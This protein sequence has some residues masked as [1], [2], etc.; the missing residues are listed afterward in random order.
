MRSHC[1]SAG[2]I[3]V[4]AIVTACP[5]LSAAG[6][7]EP[8]LFDT[9][10]QSWQPLT[11][12]AM[13]VQGRWTEIASGDT[14]HAFEGDAVISDDDVALV[15]R[16]GGPGAEVY[17]RSTRGWQ[18]CAALLP[19]G[20]A[21][22]RTLGSLKIAAN[23]GGRIDLDA[24]YKSKEDSTV[25]VR[26]GLAQGRF[27]VR[28]LDGARGVR[29][30]APCHY[31]VLPDPD[32][33]AVL[34]GA[35]AMTEGQTAMAGSGFL[36]HMLA[37][38]SVIVM[39]ESD[40]D[41]DIQLNV[42]GSGT[43]KLIESSDI[44]FGKSRRVQVRVLGQRSLWR[45]DE[46]AGE[47]D[48]PPQAKMTWRWPSPAPWSES[49]A[50]P[51]QRGEMA[52]FEAGSAK[53]KRGPAAPFM[54]L[55]DAG[56]ASDSPLT[57]G[58]LARSR[59][60]TQVPEEHLAH[61]FEGDVVFMN[62]KLAAVLRRNGTG[63]E[64]YSRGPG[65][66]RL[67]ATLTP[68]GRG[69]ASRLRSVGVVKNASDG[70][71]VDALFDAS[72]GH[73]LGLRYEL[74]MGQ[75]FVKVEPLE[76]T[77]GLQL[78]APCRFG[79]LPDFFADDMVIDA[80]DIPVDRAELPSE[81]FLMHLIG[82]GEAAIMAVWENSD[83][84][85]RVEFEGDGMRREMVSSEVAFGREGAVWV[86]ILS[87]P[88]IWH[89]RDI[90]PQDK[91]REIPLEWQWPFPG[92]WRVTWRRSDGL[93]D[94]W[95]MLTE[96]Y[97]GSFK[98][99]GLFE[100]TEDAWTARDWWGGGHPRT[101]I[102]SGLGRFHY[103]C[104]V[105]RY[106]RGYLEP[107]KKKLEFKG[108]AIVYPLNR[109]SSTP[110]DKFTVVDV[111]RATL[112]V[113]P[114]EY[115]LDVEGQDESFEGLP[116]CTIQDILDDIYEKGQQRQKQAEVSRALDDVIAFI[117]LIRGR[118]DDYGAF[119]EEMEAY[120][121]G[122]KQNDPSLAARIAELESLTRR[123]SGAIA[124][125]REGI[126]SVEVAS[127]LVDQFR[128]SLVGYEGEDAEQKCKQFTKQWVGIGG[129]QDQLVAECRSA[130]KVLRQ[131]AAMVMAKDPQMAKIAGEVRNRTR[132]ILRN[133]V[134]Y[135]APHH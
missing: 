5:Y 103:P 38:G 111:V 32:G 54:V 119:A 85:V 10:S 24:A 93:A 104:W 84:D 133:P 28:A 70:V 95:E 45:V 87:D 18:I 9:R 73:A 89:M 37:D 51:Q 49:T 34:L 132:D 76:E 125:K 31:V 33:D 56:T 15:V 135:E 130:V 107:M 43:R 66:P 108:P 88:G 21:R 96:S 81:N 80:R 4:L 29:V 1:T 8:R 41:D 22:V 78:E 11:P 126:R 110:L 62:D 77:M 35:A 117:T 123:V 52:E 3:T 127:G 72:G 114:C 74:G 60:W 116:T 97:D 115:I 63:A 131:R 12:V 101:R 106:G 113:G 75:P 124:R 129:N 91:G 42:E 121:A 25:G 44:R 36:L 82:D 67:R 109:L 27:G 71:V 39:A 99:H 105:D 120:L 19:L 79:L 61:D 2:L 102:A 7:T 57:S 128:E 64:V 94:S 46:T 55:Y 100:E 90:S 65:R 14:T 53:K 118:I 26:F 59:E 47:G 86:A 50:P 98:K 92:L 69:S 40:S 134:N 13:S 48:Q 58:D 20:D 6:R 83:Q 112:G 16:Q 68:L 30:E 122:Q 23:S 17:T